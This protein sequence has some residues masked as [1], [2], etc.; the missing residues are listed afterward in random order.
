MSL[1]AT[2]FNRAY[3]RWGMSDVHLS[4]D[5]RVLGTTY[6]TSSVWS[7]PYKSYHAPF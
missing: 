4:A 7:G 6:V 3:H 2:V 5:G 1:R